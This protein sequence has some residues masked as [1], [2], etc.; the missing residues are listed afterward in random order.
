LNISVWVHICRI[1]IKSHVDLIIIGERRLWY[2]MQMHLSNF[3][4]L[5]RTYNKPSPRNKASSRKVSRIIINF[6]SSALNSGQ[7]LS[8]F[9][10]LYFGVILYNYIRLNSLLYFVSLFLQFGILGFVLLFGFLV[11]FC[12]FHKKRSRITWGLVYF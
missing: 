7:I 4:S 3:I 10:I 1:I 2:I 8:L 9:Q 6:T 5:I 11:L 12:R